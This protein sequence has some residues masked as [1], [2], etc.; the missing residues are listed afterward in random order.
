MT[1]LHTF[2]N[3]TSRITDP[4]TSREAGRGDRQTDRQKALAVLAQFPQR[5]TDFELGAKMQRKQTSAGKQRLELQRFGY[6]EDAGC[7]RP[8]DTGSRAIVWR[9]TPAGMKAAGNVVAVA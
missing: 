1:N 9:I 2:L 4:R 6:V 5:L 7:T 3:P 8:S